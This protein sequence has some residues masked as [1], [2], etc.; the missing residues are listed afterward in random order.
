MWTRR[1]WRVVA[2]IIAILFLPRVLLALLVIPPWQQPDEPQNVAFVR[3]LQHNAGGRTV[4]DLTL[5]FR[6]GIRDDP[7]S[8]RLIVA[9]MVE[10]G[11]WRHFGRSTPS[12]P[13]T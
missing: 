6:G 9:S 12:P 4:D 11:W 7:L 13:P 3:L 1:G 8:E 5:R 10:H 2:S